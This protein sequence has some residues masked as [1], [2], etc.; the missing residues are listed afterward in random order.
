MGKKKKEKLSLSQVIENWKFQIKPK[1][2]LIWCALCQFSCRVSD[3]LWITLN[4]SISACVLSTSIITLGEV[5][6][7][8][9][10]KN[11]PTINS[12]SSTGLSGLPVFLCWKPNPHFESAHNYGLQVTSMNTQLKAWI[13]KSKRVEYWQAHP[14]WALVRQLQKSEN[15]NLEGLKY[16]YNF[17][18]CYCHVRQYGIT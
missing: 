8:L 5:L 4:P 12:N 11:S 9:P 10:L 16:V 1:F 3:F 18:L 17:L 14:E 13:T 7:S 15:H 6:Q 2:L